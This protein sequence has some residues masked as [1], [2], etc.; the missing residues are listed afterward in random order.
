MHPVDISPEEVQDP[1]E[2]NVPGQGL[3]RDP[4]RSPLQ[5]DHSEQAGFTTGTSWLPLAADYPTMNVAAEHADARSVLNLYRQ[6]TDLRRK[7][8]ALSIVSYQAV[9]AASVN[10]VKSLRSE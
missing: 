4:E 10:P 7:E 8:G 2:K 6:L 9:K 3:G 5:W 1:L